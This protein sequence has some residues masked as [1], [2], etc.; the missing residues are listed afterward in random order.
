MAGSTK[1]ELTSPVNPQHEGY[2]FIYTQIFIRFLVSQLELMSYF[3][4]WVVFFSRTRF[5]F[6]S[7]WRCCFHWCIFIRIS[8]FDI[9]NGWKFYTVYGKYL[10]S[11]NILYIHI[12]V[13]V[14]ILVLIIF[15]LNNI[16]EIRKWGRKPRL[17]NKYETT[18]RNVH[19]LC[20]KN[21]YKHTLAYIISIY[22]Y[23]VYGFFICNI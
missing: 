20:H 7:E 1:L 4:T 17:W 14:S 6:S 13:W 5:I 8:A 10:L 23:I 21:L 9:W 12:N 3:Y 22:L 11:G 19:R 15:V 16:G 2:L 18:C